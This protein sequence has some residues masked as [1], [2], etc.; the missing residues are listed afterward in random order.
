MPARFLLLITVIIWGATFVA[1]KI[2]VAYVNPAELIG[3]RLI[4]A[5]PI[6]ALIA[7]AKRVR[8]RF[9]TKELWVVL[10]SSTVICAH[11]LIQITGIKY[12]SATNTGWLIACTPLVLAVLSSVFLR[13]K[14][15]KR[16]IIGIT[17]ATCGVVA[18]VSHGDLTHL[19]WLRNVG[20][21]LVLASAFTWAIYTVTTRDLSRAHDP[22]VVTIAVLLPAT[23]GLT[24]YML[25]TSD[26]SRF[27]QMPMSATLSLLFL[28][29]L[30]MA[31]GQWFWQEG[32]AKVGAAKAGIFLYLEPISTT[33]LA[34]SY[35]DEEFGV[36][37]AVGALL[38]LGGVY[39]AERRSGRGQPKSTVE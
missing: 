31:L 8:F 30:G 3:L 6:L 9:S 24:I 21:W 29:I 27:L 16:E 10:A 37:S 32:L 7:V 23:V 4:I 25:L 11:F 22:V 12:T 2:V 18:L 34:V 38:I 19:G 5:M 33:I 15:G 36:A 17:I 35:L 26:W 28:G 1:T 20:D 14:I 13:E 39:W